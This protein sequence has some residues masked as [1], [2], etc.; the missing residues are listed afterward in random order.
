M[1]Y[2]FPVVVLAAVAVVGYGCVQGKVLT[3]PAQSR[4]TDTTSTTISLIS[5][6][7]TSIDGTVGQTASLTATALNQSGV[8]LGGTKFIWAASNTQVASVDSVGSVTLVGAGSANISASAG[9]LTVSIPAH[10]TAGTIRV[11]A[12][13]VTPSTVTLNPGNTAQL[14]AAAMDS[15]GN[16]LAGTTI[17]WSSSNPSVATVSTSGLLSAVAVGSAVITASGGGK[18][19]TANVTVVAQSP[20]SVASVAVSPTTASVITGRTTQFTA[21][22]KDSVG[23]VLG[24][25]AITWSSNNSNVATVSSTGLVTGVASGTVTISAAS[26]GQQG[27]AHITVDPVPVASVVVSPGSANLSA[28]QTLLL[29]AT[30]KDANGAPLGGQTITWTS[31]DPYTA[32][33]Q[34]NGLVTV[35][36]TGGVG[37]TVITASTGGKSGTSTINLIAAPVASVTAAPTS[38]SLTAG[39][40]SQLSAT[41]KDQ[42]GDV[43][44]TDPVSWSSSNNGVAKVSSSGLVT[45]VATGSATITVTIG[46]MQATVDVTVSQ[47]AVATVTV[48]PT[49][50]SLTGGQSSGLTATAKDGSGNILTGRS[51]SWSS[52]N[53]GVATAS[54]SGVVTGAAAGSATITVTIGGKS[55]TATA[56]VTASQT[57]ATVTVAPGSSTLAVGNQ[58]QLTATDKTSGGTVVT[59]QSVTW[60][61]SNNGVAQVSSSGIVTAVSAGGATIT[62]TS[63]GKQGTASLTVQPASGGGPYHEPSG[64]A[65]QINTGPMATVPAQ[66]YP[67]NTWSEGSAQFTNWSPN[68]ISNVGEWAGNISPVPGGTGL[69]VNYLPTLAGG[70]SPVRF[71]TS[72]PNAGSG[73]LYVRFMLRLSPNWTL[74]QASGLKVMEPRTI[75]PG[76]ENHVIGVGA[77]GQAQD[78]SQMWPGF[79]VQFAHSGYSANIPG[80]ALGQ[81]PIPSQVFS[82][83]NANLGGSA[84]GSWHVI[85]YYCQ[86]ESPAGATNGQLT[87]WVDGTQVFQTGAPGSKGTPDGGMRFFE[88]GESMGYNYLMFDP[89]YGGDSSNDHPPYLIYWDVDQLYVSTK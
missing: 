50:V 71:G 76:S 39:Q 36:K 35:V 32:T 4:Q 52:S 28:K 29:S 82:T 9:G 60:S 26:G 44:T 6:N 11:F 48:A 25:R 22:V 20:A 83:G 85:E 73:Y 43:I 12:V 2:R 55:A 30:P 13:S 21:T 64:M 78:G 15:A 63:A 84:R 61:S 75:N 1:R 59:G 8:T 70:Y 57:V 87:I 67:N 7:P 89:T 86:P 40:T 47:V 79:I 69:R 68:S 65:T 3:D 62:A 53:T 10:A 80:N 33:V 17:T 49:A 18:S 74:S 46:G 5:I 38:V 34:S 24:G 31:S 88:P 56:T 23:N 54:S 81:T 41:A 77:D 42:Y 14:S 66:T 16:T 58:L 37:Y 27:T 72:I 45:A 51:E 19:A